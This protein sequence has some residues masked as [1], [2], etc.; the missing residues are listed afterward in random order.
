MK[1]VLITGGSGLIG[2]IL[3]KKLVEIG[4]EVK[5]FTSNKL[6]ADGVNSFYWNIENNVIDRDIVNSVDFIVHLAGAGIAEKSW[7]PKRKKLI[8]DSRVK[9]ADLIFNTL[10]A[11]K[12]MLSAFISASGTGFYGA[13]NSSRIFTE[14]DPPAYDFLGETCRLWEQSTANFKVLG[15][16][17][18][19]IRTGIVLTKHGGALEK[20]LI[21]IKFGIG[22]ALGNGKQYVP[23]IHI[24]DLCNIYIKA[25][26]DVNIKGPHNAV[27]PEYITNIEFT[28]ALAKSVNKPFWFPNVPAFLLRILFGEMADVLLKGSR[29]SSKKIQAENFVFEFTDV[30][31]AFN[32]LFGEK[33]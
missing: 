20:M 1:T 23:W 15:V 18:V 8:L 14:E 5:T 25:I 9:S 3:Q 10:D 19:K 22:S 2:N 17:T 21:P 11:E 26:Q 32:N 12:K 30:K 33:S 29:V 24:N 27:A 4:Y 16:R 28:R 7:T 6:A 13:V 31:N